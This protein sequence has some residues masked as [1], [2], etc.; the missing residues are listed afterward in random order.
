[1][2]KYLVIIPISILLLAFIHFCSHSGEDRTERLFSTNES[3]IIKGNLLRIPPVL[4]RSYNSYT[5][6]HDTKFNP[7]YMFDRNEI[8]GWIGNKD[9]DN[10]RIAILNFQPIERDFN[11]THIKIKS[12]IQNGIMNFK[13]YSRPKTLQLQFYK[14]IEN[15]LSIEDDENNTEENHITFK[16]D[17]DDIKEIEKEIITEEDYS[18]E[19]I[20]E[21]G[22]S[23]DD[24]LSNNDEDT[25]ITSDIEILDDNRK[26]NNLEESIP[27]SDLEETILK[28]K[29]INQFSINIEDIQ[30]WQTNKIPK[31]N[32]DFDFVNIFVK[33]KYNGEKYPNQIA[34]SEMEFLLSDPTRTVDANKY[35]YLYDKLKTW[36]ESN[37]KE[38][39]LR[40]KSTDIFYSQYIMSYKTSNLDNWYRNSVKNNQV[41]RIIVP[42]FEKAAQMIDFGAV[43]KS[44]LDYINGLSRYF[45][46]AKIY[47]LKNAS[48]RWNKYRETFL[49]Y[50]ENSESAYKD[51]EESPI[52]FPF[53]KYLGTSFNQPKFQKRLKDSS[54]LLNYT[55]KSFFNSNKNIEHFFLVR[56]HDYKPKG[57]IKYVLY[58]DNERLNSVK[59]LRITGS[60]NDSDPICICIY[61]KK[62]RLVKVMH[63]EYGKE[64]HFFIIWDD[65][66]KV[67]KILIM[68]IGSFGLKRIQKALAKKIN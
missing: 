14:I 65:N 3:E 66:D 40:G 45:D 5:D 4:I 38:E 39:F 1:M 11:L 12:G 29:L 22:V 31:M 56:N 7:Y 64:E 61:D 17:E 18:D 67:E 10:G 44:Q 2:K 49:I 23:V 46:S 55:L 19:I 63:R 59:N 25:E 43:P 48:Y 36:Y 9:V 53:M 8:T 37:D 33:D 57:K 28:V 47:A 51:L 34:I 54:A 35:D 52:Y 60:M 26:S 27:D 20:P 21:E 30:E 62:E 58:Y 6:E 16:S 32:F 50:I 41:Y 68:E 24:F 42:T 13:D 15:S